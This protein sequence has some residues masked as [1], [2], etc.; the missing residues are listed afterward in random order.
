MDEKLVFNSDLNLAKSPVVNIAASL[1][2]GPYALGYQTAFDSGK[3]ALTKHNLK[4]LQVFRWRNLLEEQLSAGDWSY[5]QQRHRRSF[6][7]RHRLQVRSGQGRQRQG[8]G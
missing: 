7:L 6:Q 5:L 2:H 8:Q 1:G 4:R 3:S